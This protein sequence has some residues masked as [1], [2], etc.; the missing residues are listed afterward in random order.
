[1]GTR[2]ERWGGEGRGLES[3]RT[4]IGLIRREG[5]GQL[6]GFPGRS[7][8]FNQEKLSSPGH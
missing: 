4:V 5:E 2:G 1:M 3:L 8:S 6:G 7:F